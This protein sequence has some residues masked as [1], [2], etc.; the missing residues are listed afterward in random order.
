VGWILYGGRADNKSGGASTYDG[1]GT[2]CSG[3]V[4]AG[5]CWAGYNWSPWR[6]TTTSL[7]TSYYSTQINDAN[8]NLEPGDILNNPG[9]HVVTVYQYTAGHL[10][11]PDSQ[12]ID[13]CG[14][15]HKVDIHEHVNIQE[16][17]LDKGYTARELV[18]HG[19]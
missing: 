19:Q 11:M 1:Y 15:N 12:I 5:A 16:E 18:W 8:Q 3:L 4:S 2:D 13:S 9:V 10:N 17:Y 6:A 14:G 7:N